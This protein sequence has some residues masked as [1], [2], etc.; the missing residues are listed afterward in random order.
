LEKIGETIS[1]HLHPFAE[2]GDCVRFPVLP[3]T[4]CVT[5]EQTSYFPH[6][7]RKEGGRG[8]DSM[9]GGKRKREE[10]GE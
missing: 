8:N 5:L 6:L 4:Y 10:K 9:E 2:K 1:C 7:L 3:P